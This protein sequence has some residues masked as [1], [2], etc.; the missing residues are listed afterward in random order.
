MPS[1]FQSPYK[2]QTQQ[3]RQIGHSSAASTSSGSSKIATREIRPPIRRPAAQKLVG[4]PVK[5][6][7]P[8]RRDYL[9]DTFRKIYAKGRPPHSRVVPFVRVVAQQHQQQHFV[10]PPMEQGAAKM[11]GIECAPR[12]TPPSDLNPDEL[13]LHAGSSAFDAS[14]LANAHSTPRTQEFFVGSSARAEE[15]DEDEDGDSR[16]GSLQIAS[17]SRAE[18]GLEVVDATAVGD[19]ETE[20]GGALFSKDDEPFDDFQSRATNV[21]P[22]IEVAQLPSPSL[23]N[24]KNPGI[25]FE[26]NPRSLRRRRFFV[27]PRANCHPANEDVHPLLAALTSLRTEVGARREEVRARRVN[28]AGDAE[29]EARVRKLEAVGRDRD[30]GDVVP[31]GKRVEGAVCIHPLAHLLGGEDNDKEEREMNVD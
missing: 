31:V 23:S 29:L 3:T 25:A 20:E 1:L 28:D 27:L 24:S 21:I 30:V 18:F 16:E 26:N 2:V 9:T 4:G 14:I 13:Q 5:R 19:L 8:L 12:P 15:E 11:D 22:A 17:L 7:E 10:P 6:S